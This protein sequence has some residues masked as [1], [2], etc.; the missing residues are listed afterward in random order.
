MI[1]DKAR[2]DEPM[3]ILDLEALLNFFKFTFLKWQEYPNATIA[4][5]ALSSNDSLLPLSGGL[6]ASVTT[7][8]FD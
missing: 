3:S 1:V 7:S 2:S 5:S 6:L 8:D 4:G